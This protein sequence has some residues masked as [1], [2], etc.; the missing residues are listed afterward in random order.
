MNPFTVNVGDGNLTYISA[1]TT[2][3]GNYTMTGKVVVQDGATLT[4]A[5][6]TVVKATFTANQ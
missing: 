4:I 5:A 2:W 3:D 1:D 6:G